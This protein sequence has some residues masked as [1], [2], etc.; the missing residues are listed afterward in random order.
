MAI[1]IILDSGG[2]L[3]TQVVVQCIRK[4]RLL[5][6]LFFLIAK[7]E[8][9]SKTLL[10]CI[11]QIFSWGRN[12]DKGWVRRLPYGS[13][14]RFFRA[15]Y[16]FRAWNLYSWKATSSIDLLTY[17][18][19]IWASTMTFTWLSS[20]SSLDRFYPFSFLD[21]HGLQKLLSVSN[22]RSCNKILI[23][24]LLRTRWILIVGLTTN[25]T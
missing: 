16:L 8:R 14:L 3:V 23:R 12:R 11:S 5:I 2:D 18:N 19:F 6:L 20:L 10:S 1:F 22:H 9:A 25:P 17:L 4:H 21:V 15:S 7:L 13:L 24:I